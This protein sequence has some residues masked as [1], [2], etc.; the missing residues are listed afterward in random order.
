[1][2]PDLP[3]LIRKCQ[4]EETALRAI[5]ESVAAAF[6]PPFAA[7]IR[8]RIAALLTQAGPHRNALHRIHSLHMHSPEFCSLPM[9]APEQQYFRNLMRQLRLYPTAIS[10]LQT[11]LRQ[12][13]L[14]L[15]PPSPPRYGPAAQTLALHARLWDRM[16]AHL[17]PH[18]PDL[19]QDALSSFQQNHTGANA[20]ARP[21][22]QGSAPCYSHANR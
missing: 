11:V 18:P 21:S 8:A 14:P 15:F 5:F 10:H 4:A 3:S 1:M 7:K 22:G 6:A 13:P 16:H 17:S 12:R 19:Y 2:Q 9:H 20:E